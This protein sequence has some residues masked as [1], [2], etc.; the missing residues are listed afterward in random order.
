MNVTEENFKDVSYETNT[1][2]KM[3]QT[4]FVILYRTLVQCSA[5]LSVTLQGEA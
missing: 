3:Y 1:N 5:S 4:D 2:I